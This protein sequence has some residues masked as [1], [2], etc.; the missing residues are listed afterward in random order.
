VAITG[1]SKI[2]IRGS[3]PR[4]PADKGL[5]PGNCRAT[6]SRPAFVFHKEV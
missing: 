4:G 1:I 6:H 3:N 2:S 5:Q